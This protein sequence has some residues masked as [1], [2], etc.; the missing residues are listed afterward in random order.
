MSK[1][2]LS[3]ERK[4]FLKTNFNSIVPGAL[5]SADELRYYNLI[6]AGK[7]RAK[8]SIRLEGKFLSG[9]I[10][11]II[12]KVA[13]KKGL[14]LKKYIDLNSA[15]IIKLIES[16]FTQVWKEFD[17]AID[18]VGNGRKKIFFIDDGNG[19]IKMLKIEV[20]EQLALLENYAKSSS[21]IV[22]IFTL[23]KVYKTGRMELTIPQDYDGYSYDSLYD[24]LD[25]F[26][27]IDYIISD[28]SKTEK[29]GDQ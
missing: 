17:K 4:E 29:T 27:G 20:I 5:K 6:K 26:D 11:N 7:M 16:G 13:E 1:V 2:N 3:S 19:L 21:D 12:K 25:L 18:L 10:V 9:E 23:V 22:A 24:Y 15:D 28:K 14:S 8:N